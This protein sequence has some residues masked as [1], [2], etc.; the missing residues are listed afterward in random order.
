MKDFTHHT[1]GKKLFARLLIMYHIVILPIIALGLYL[2]IWSYNNASEEISRH[3][4]N[5]LSMYLDSLN[6]EM[7]WME[8]QQYNLLQDNEL[9]SV[10]VTWDVMSNVEQ[11]ESMHYLVNR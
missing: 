1:V 3:T 5:Q 4:E 7:G 9:Q 10:A 2:Y 11:K 8:S 6:R